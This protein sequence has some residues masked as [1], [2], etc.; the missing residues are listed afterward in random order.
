M[1]L[2][3]ESR[4]TDSTGRALAEHNQRTVTAQAE[5]SRVLENTNEVNG[6]QL[7]A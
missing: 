2:G 7:L 6:R 5:N 1:R 4:A 3:N